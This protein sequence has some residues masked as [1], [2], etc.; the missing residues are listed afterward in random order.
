MSRAAAHTPKPADAKSKSPSTAAFAA[1]HPALRSSRYDDSG[2]SSLPWFVQ[3]KLTVK[4]APT[5][6]AIPAPAPVHRVLSTPG[7][8][9]SSSQ[10]AAFEP[11]FGVDLADVRLHDDAGAARSAAAMGAVAYT[12]QQHVVMD[13]RRFEPGTPQ[14]KYVIAHELAHSLQQRS[15]R[16]GRPATCVAPRA[17]AEA[18]AAA[19][20]A[21]FD[22]PF[23][24]V[25]RLE[26][27]AVQRLDMIPGSLGGSDIDRATALTSI[28]FVDNNIGDVGLRED[29][30]AGLS[31]VFKAVTIKYNDG[32]ILDI[33]IDPTTLRPPMPAGMLQMTRFRRHTG[34]NKIFPLTWR[35][36]NAELAALPG[37]PEGTVFF[38]KDITPNIMAGF[39]A[40]LISRAFVFAGDLA[41]IWSV[42]LA[43]SSA[44]QIFSAVQAATITGAARASAGVAGMSGAAARAAAVREAEQQAF[45]ATKRALIAELKAAGVRF[46]ESDIIWI[47][48]DSSKR[49]V[50]LER[51]NATAGLQH[52]MTR[53]GADFASVGVDGENN[54]ARLILDTVTTK[55]P[56]T[57]GST[58]SVYRVMMG[59]SLREMQISVGSNGFV[60]TA[61]P[62]GAVAP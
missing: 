28:D 36:T 62:M 60:V 20:S 61:F 16:E 14:E 26:Q 4:D 12:Y 10:R 49:I 32:S 1:L 22:Q 6:N 39:D 9:L 46:T 45:E 58:G 7:R 24:V 48:R 2:P 56:T 47:A 8:S 30:S 51:G 59:G 38:A 19:R 42:A 43:V 29:R 34:S 55:A 40:A 31:V 33:P 25:H 21:V 54:V 35:G 27:G 52:I 5:E 41:V 50:W 57:V 23:A 37:V 13:R 17:E 44:I 18:D 53:H 15:T 3:A 11:R